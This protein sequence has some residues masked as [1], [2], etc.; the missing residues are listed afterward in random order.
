MN[1]PEPCVRCAHLYVDAMVPDHVIEAAPDLVGRSCKLERNM[2]YTDMP[3][4]V[5]PLFEK[6]DGHAT[7]Q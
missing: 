3:S 5:C 4:E 6:W 1:T 2:P 7:R